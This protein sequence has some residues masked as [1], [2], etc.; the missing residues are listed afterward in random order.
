MGGSS[1]YGYETL[2]GKIHY[3]IYSDYMLLDYII[4]VFQ[5]GRVYQI[6]DDDGEIFV[7]NSIQDYFSEKRYE[8]EDSKVRGVYRLNGTVMYKY[9]GDN[10]SYTYTY[11]E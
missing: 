5:K 8:E 1:T 9:W 3:C 6:Q 7:A 10:G 4:S 11:S 2:D